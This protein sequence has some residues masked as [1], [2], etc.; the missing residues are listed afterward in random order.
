[1]RHRGS[2]ATSVLFV[3]AVLSAASAVQ[4][5]QFRVIGVQ[6]GGGIAGYTPGL[7]GFTTS[8]AGFYNRAGNTTTSILPSDPT[9]WTESV[10]NHIAYDS[11]LTVSGSGPSRLSVEDDVGDSLSSQ[12]RAFYGYTDTWWSG[13]LFPLLGNG[14]HLGDSS[15]SSGQPPFSADR[16]PNRARGGWLQTGNGELQSGPSPLTGRQSVFIGQLTVNRGATLVGSV[17]LAV[18]STNTQIPLTL[19]GPPTLSEISPG[20]FRLFS[21]RSYLVATH[22]DLSHSRSGGN[23]GTG[24]G[25]TQRFG[26]ADVYHVWIDL[27]PQP[28]CL[29]DANRDGAVNFS[30]ITT[31]LANFGNSDNIGDSNFDRVT[32]FADVTRTLSSF[33]SVC[34]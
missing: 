9:I 15:S 29:G 14:T 26:P 16:P 28:T 3:A 32:N 21:M 13:I 4:A 23:Q 19:N 5:Q 10:N 17:A 24:S 27:D 12:L 6:G 22:D 33:G 11:Y 34:Q 25:S 30:D 18:L 2:H 31:V 7:E 8:G 1:M 20:V